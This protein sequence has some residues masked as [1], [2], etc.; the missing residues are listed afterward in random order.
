MGRMD[1][2][3]YNIGFIDSTGRAYKE[4]TA[5]VQETHKRLYEVHAGKVPPYST[6]PKA[7]E[8]GAPSTP[9]DLDAFHGG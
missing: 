4:L 8:A 5:A 3:N 1:G 9:W 7:S 2:E 6:R